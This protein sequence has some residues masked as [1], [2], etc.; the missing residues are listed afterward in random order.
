[1]LLSFVSDDLKD[2]EE[3]VT[4][5]LQQDSEALEFVSDRLKDKEGYFFIIP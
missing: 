1:M 3:V 4:I 2:D 5:A